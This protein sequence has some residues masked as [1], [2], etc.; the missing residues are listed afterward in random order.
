MLRK[1]FQSLILLLFVFTSSSHS[2]AY[3]LSTQSRWIIDDSTG[4]RVKLVCGNWA[5]H[6]QP[7]IPEGLDRIPLKELV[8]ELVKNR[9]NCV[10]L[11][12]AV[13]MWTRHAHGIVNNTFN[14]LDAPEVVA[15]IAKYNPSILKMTHIEA[16]DAVVN[17]LGA[18]NVKVLLDNHVSEPKWCCNDDDDNGFFH[19][20][21][22]DPQEWIHGLTLAAK[23]FYGHQPI[24]AMSLRNELR[25]PRQNLRDWYKYMSHAAL[26]IHKTNPNVLVVISGLNY[27]TELQFLR[28]NPLKIDLGEKMVYEAHLYSWSGIGTLKLK[29]F[30]S[31][32]PLNRICAENIEGLDQSAGF[33]TSGK[34]AVPLIITEFGFDQTGSSVE[35]N[36]E[37]K[38]QLDESFGVVDATWHKLRYPNF[39][40]KFQ[41]LQRKNQDPTSKVSEAYIMY[42]PLTGQCGQ[43]NDKN[44]LEIGSCENQTRWI[45]NGSQILLN[46]SKKCLTAIG[47][48]LPVAISD[49]YENKNSSWKSESLSRLH[50]A[51]VDQNGKHLCLHKDYNSSF[52]VTSKCI[53]INDD[54][55]CLDDPQSQWFQLVA[56]NV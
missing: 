23:H 35:D 44:E 36:R 29:E 40:D 39:A 32:Q 15:G 1:S 48:G 43:V 47:E 8:G 21:H 30:W 16:F 24:V 12:Y 3:P 17:E 10:R 53:C 46:D 7:M 31:K 5:G 27:D 34:N 41:L 52:V 51:T 14:Y 11:T 45:Y 20:Q 50:L 13:Y 55:L 37:D 54:S 25:G 22:F 19:D 56:T 42:H 9:F 28:N 38:L 6:L 4:E 2:N 18:R 26:V 49:D 33:L